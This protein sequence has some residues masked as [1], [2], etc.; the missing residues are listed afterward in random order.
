MAQLDQRFDLLTGGSRNAGARQRTLR[1]TIDWSFGLLSPEEE[2]VFLQCAVFAGGFDLEAALAVCIPD[3]GPIPDSASNSPDWAESPDLKRVL[4]S[5]VARSLLTRS[6]PD[7]P[8]PRYDCLQTLRIY[9]LEKLGS[10]KL[11]SALLPLARRHADHL[12]VLARRTA[13]H[14]QGAVQAEVLDTLARDIH[15][16][17]KALEWRFV[18]RSGDEAVAMTLALFPYWYNRGPGREGRQWLERALQVEALS[19]QQRGEALYCLSALIN[20]AGDMPMS[21]SLLIESNAIFRQLGDRIALGRGL[22]AEART[23]RVLGRSEAA[24]RCAEQSL[25][26]SAATGDAVGSAQSECFLGLLCVEE[27]QFEAAEQLL[28]RA[29]A[30]PRG[31]EDQGALNQG[32]VNLGLLYLRTLRH[33]AATAALEESLEIARR[34]DSPQRIIVSLHYLG[35]LALETG[36]LARA[37]LHLRAVLTQLLDLEAPLMGEDTLLE[38]AR[39]ELAMGRLERAAH[40]AGFSAS[41]RRLS[42]LALMPEE[43][44]QQDQL[45]SELASA[46]DGEQLAFIEKTTSGWS[47]QVGYAY[48]LGQRMSPSAD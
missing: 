32:L 16:L 43:K 48:A 11:G 27:E 19:P 3:A 30:E 33:D 10:D 21:L 46:M 4:D 20:Q 40:L 22:R 23:Q 28:A 2:R 41:L 26:E 31:R 35:A 42:G 17:S 34:L 37:E 39:V 12:A 44:R 1:A 47:I 29:T 38:L 8:T 7:A 25:T 36:Q 6:Q 15:N 5:L 18:H 24:R 14:T 13:E 45:W 9:A